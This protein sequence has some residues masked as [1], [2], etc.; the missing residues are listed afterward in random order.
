MEIK[1]TE[2]ESEQMF[3]DALCNA[4]G[5]GYMNGYG[6][7]LEC[8]RSQYKDSKEYLTHVMKGNLCYED[9][10]M[11]VLRDGGKLTFVDREG[12][13]DM[14]RG[15]T[16][17]EVHERVCKTNPHALLRILNE[18]GDASDADQLLQTVFFEEVIFG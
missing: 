9:V 5:T 16:L 1:L 3:Y 7:E 8:E 11:Q 13:G 18:G 14:T 10:L 17:K 12:E 2:K 15:I 6:L 4:V